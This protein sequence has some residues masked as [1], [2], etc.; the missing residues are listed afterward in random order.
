MIRTDSPTE[1]S[2]RLFARRNWLMLPS[3]VLV[4]SDPE[5]PDLR[6]LGQNLIDHSILNIQPGR[7]ISHERSPKSFVVKALDQPQPRRPG[8]SDDVLPFL[9]SL[10]N[11]S[12]QAIQL[13]VQPGVFEH[14]P[15]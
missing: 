15:H 8:D 2:T 9:V 1:T 12:W 5:Y 7:P 13:P 11:L 6:D 14:L 3:S 4:R 10:E